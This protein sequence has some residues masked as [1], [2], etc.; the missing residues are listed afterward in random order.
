MRLLGA[1]TSQE[2]SGKKTLREICTSADQYDAKEA[3]EMDSSTKLV[4]FVQ[5]E[6]TYVAWAIKY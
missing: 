2:S 1:L 6:E 3:V 5:A 4:P